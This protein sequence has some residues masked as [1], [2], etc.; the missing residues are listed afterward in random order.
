MF[1]GWFV[2]DDRICYQKIMQVWMLWM[3]ETLDTRIENNLCI[4]L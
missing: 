1:G 4:Y 2:C 3:N